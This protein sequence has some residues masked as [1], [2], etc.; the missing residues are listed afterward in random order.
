MYREEVSFRFVKNIL[1]KITLPLR[2]MPLPC[3][4]TVLHNK[5][6]FKISKIIRTS[7]SSWLHLPDLLLFV[8]KI[9]SYRQIELDIS[10]ISVLSL[11]CV[12]Y[13]KDFQYFLMVLGEA[14]LKWF[15]WFRLILYAKCGNGFSNF[16]VYLFI[17]PLFIS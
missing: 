15:V 2:K 12:V 10:D 16:I 9:Y 11:N 7:L 1:L 4:W 5:S 8:F 3:L 13:A 17:L 14:E 6:I